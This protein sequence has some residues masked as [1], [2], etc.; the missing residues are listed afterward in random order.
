MSDNL[1]IFLS[2]SLSS[3]INP[4]VDF[5]R[6]DFQH[7]VS[8]F[9]ISFL[10]WIKKIGS[11]E[12]SGLTRAGIRRG[13]TI[14]ILRPFIAN[15]NGG[16]SS[17]SKQRA[18]RRCWSLHGIFFLIQRIISSFPVSSCSFD[19]RFFLSFFFFKGSWGEASVNEI[20]DLSKRRGERRRGLFL[21]F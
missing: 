10:S 13:K 11:D 1:E 2:L 17:K 20:E 15:F 19:H 21:F 14:L 8:F 6:I 7:P 18:N 12:S 4:R 5:R 9:P 16:K 3:I